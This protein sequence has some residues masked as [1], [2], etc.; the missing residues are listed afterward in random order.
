[1]PNGGDTGERQLLTIT[2]GVAGV[3]VIGL[4]VFVYIGLSKLGDLKNQSKGFKNKYSAQVAAIR[5]IR[6]IDDNNTRL[7]NRI[8]QYEKFIVK[9]EEM[10]DVLDQ[11]TGRALQV[12]LNL[13]NWRREE[14]KPLNP[15]AAE[16]YEKV[17]YEF[18]FTGSFHQIVKFLND[19]EAVEELGRLVVV[20]P[21]SIVAAERGLVPGVESF[22]GHKFSVSMSLY[23]YRE[24][25]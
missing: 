15:E 16:T 2:L 6:A 17:V 19:V 11:I 5:D 8:E 9:E 18:Q 21:R 3:A 10:T 13:V 24:E 14:T 12:G 7:K 25:E 1:M 23:K 20:Q 4:G 22:E